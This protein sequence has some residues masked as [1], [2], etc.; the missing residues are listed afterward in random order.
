MTDN[1]FEVICVCNIFLCCDSVCVN[2]NFYFR[3]SF[4]LVFDFC[5]ESYYIIDKRG[6][7]I[8]DDFVDGVKFLFRFFSRRVY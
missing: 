1:R 4:E 3:M 7:K 2:D 8:I 5:I 6:G